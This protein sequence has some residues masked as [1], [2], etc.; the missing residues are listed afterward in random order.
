MVRTVDL[1]NVDFELL[2]V[3]HAVRVCN[4]Q[5]LDGFMRFDAAKVKEV[6]ARVTTVKA[7]YPDTLIFIFLYYFEVY[8]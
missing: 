2:A 7:R 1:T 8:L 3:G 4:V 6:T 5:C